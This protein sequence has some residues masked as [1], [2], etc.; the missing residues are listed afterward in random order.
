MLQDLQMKDVLSTRTDWINQ[1]RDPLIMDDHQYA[2]D[3]EKFITIEGVLL[4]DPVH[5]AGNVV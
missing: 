5:K 2:D 4:K 3:D 1:G